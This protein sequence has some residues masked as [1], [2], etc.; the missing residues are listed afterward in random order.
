MSLTQWHS[1][2]KDDYPSSRFDLPTE[3]RK[4]DRRSDS[5]SREKVLDFAK[6]SCSLLILLCLKLY[7]NLPSLNVAILYDN[8]K[9]T[10]VNNLNLLKISCRSRLRIQYRS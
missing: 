7:Y 4:A 10:R 6:K 8:Q 3:I 9:K 1:L 2:I 5:A